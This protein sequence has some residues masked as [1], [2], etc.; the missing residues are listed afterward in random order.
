MK[1]KGCCS[2]PTRTGTCN[3]TSDNKGTDEKEMKKV[4]SGL[5]LPALTETVK[6]RTDITECRS[7]KNQLKLANEKLL[8]PSPTFVTFVS[9]RQ[10]CP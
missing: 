1:K 2:K 4:S 8:T 3:A 6:E 7:V 5:M 9:A 10:Y